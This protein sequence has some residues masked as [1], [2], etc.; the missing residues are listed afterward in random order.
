MVAAVGF[1][2]ELPLCRLRIPIAGIVIAIF[3]S[4]PALFFSTLLKHNEEIHLFDGHG[5][6]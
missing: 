4:I 3:L 1:F 6:F 5:I 2:A